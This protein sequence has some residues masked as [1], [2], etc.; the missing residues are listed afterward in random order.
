MKAYQ[1]NT[2]VTPHKMPDYGNVIK[3]YKTKALL[4]R[5]HQALSSKELLGLVCFMYDSAPLTM[6]RELFTVLDNMRRELNE[7][8]DCRVL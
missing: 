4:R 1:P 7:Y 3:V 8:G 6:P 2:S 5:A